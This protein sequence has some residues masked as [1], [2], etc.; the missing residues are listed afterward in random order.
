M[1][2]KLG[3]I[4]SCLIFSGCASV[5]LRNGNTAYDR[6]DYYYA[7]N[8]FE[9]ALAHK[10][11]QE[12]EIKLAD[13][14]R[15]L[16]NNAKA[17]YWYARVVKFTDNLSY[18]L[19]YAE[20][21]MKSGKYEEA[22]KWFAKYLEISKADTRALL[23]SQSC[24]SVSKYLTDSTLYNISL[25]KLNKGTESNF[26]PAY[27][28]NGIVFLSDRSYS[29]HDKFISTQT[30]RPY[31]DLFY[32]KKTEN[33]NWI[34]PEPLR[35]DINGALNEGPTSFNKAS[36]MAF[37]T[38]NSSSHGEVDVNNKDVNVLK[39]Y[40]GRLE[41]TEWKIDGEMPFNN[42]EYSIGHPSL[43]AD[44]QTMYFVSDM[45]WGYGGT[46]IYQSQFINGSWTAPKNLGAKINSMGNEMFPFILNDSTLYFAS[47]GHGGMGGLDI[48]RVRYVN[49]ETWEDPENLGYPVN[50]SMDDFALISD[51]SESSGYFTSNRFGSS[52]KIFSF[53]K[54]P[55]KLS[56]AGVVVDKA[57]NKSL[58]NVEI[59][60]HADGLKDVIIKTDEN[61]KYSTPLENGYSYSVNARLKTY[62]FNSLSVNTKAKRKSEVMNG[63]LS[64]EKINFN[65]P[66]LHYEYEFEKGESKVAYP[67]TRELDKL[68]QRLV[69]NPTLKIEIGSH[70]DSRGDDKAN[71]ALT[72]KRADAIADYLVSKG[73]ESK[74]LT[75]KGYGESVLLNSC[76]NGVLCLEED[77]KVN[78]RVEIKILGYIQ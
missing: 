15:Q 45:P 11:N 2:R 48:F 22:K 30:G 37:V 8:Y 54:N 52:D 72:Q 47:D 51:S 10:E 16:N 58:G 36:N 3:F 39:I 25:I 57:T 27:Y 4:L 53:A 78:V 19:Y 1:N 35:G 28:R 41:G 60:F 76:I 23:L 68:A 67:T 31:F 49:N 9:K 43:S 38:R 20:A 40:K 69:K 55:A 7:I 18:R 73:V 33:G 61:G 14:Y 50:S 46:D 71:L 5:K 64:L 34:D 70:T 75:A 29:G 42:K 32:A 17:E 66:E 74:R 24:D 6:G 26:A 63:N 62:Y 12:A 21:L 59:T 56:V 44:G 13:A 65:K 77:H